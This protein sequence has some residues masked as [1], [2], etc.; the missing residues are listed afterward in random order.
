MKTFITSDWHLGEDRFNIIQRPYNTVMDHIYD[1]I[2]KHNTVV[3]PSDTVIVVGD[4]V[5]QK[6]PEYLPFVSKFNGKKILV[7]G[8]H[9]NIFSD[10][11][12]SPYFDE[13]YPDGGGFKIDI[14]GVKYYV[15]HYPSTAR[16]DRFNLVGHIHA[17]WKHQL[18]ML[19]IGVDVN[20]MRHMNLDDVPFHFQA[21][22][23]FY[24]E[25]IWAAYYDSNMKYVGLRGAAGSYFKG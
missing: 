15:T 1:M 10:T 5:Y 25:D 8:N 13:I 12:L 14:K 3:T 6:T 18:N 2:K 16:S 17:T 23:K 21:I 9:D 4:V 19:N 24:D 22:S 7:R 20:H 11:D